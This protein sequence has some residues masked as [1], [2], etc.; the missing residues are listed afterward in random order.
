MHFDRTRQKLA[1]RLPGKGHVGIN[2]LLKLAHAPNYRL[3]QLFKFAVLNLQT[4]RR[5]GQLVL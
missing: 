2:Q 1:E 5:P 4:V 3:L